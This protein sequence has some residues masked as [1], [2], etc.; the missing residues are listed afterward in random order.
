MKLGARS[1]LKAKLFP[2]FCLFF[3]HLQENGS[4]SYAN[5]DTSLL[6][7]PRCGDAKHKDK[8]SWVDESL[9][10]FK[11]KGKIGCIGI[12]IDVKV[13][14]YPPYQKGLILDSMDV[15]LSLIQ[16]PSNVLGI[17]FPGLCV[18]KETYRTKTTL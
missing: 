13:T 17:P 9:N 6:N 12:I 1:A 16:L 7:K 4:P 14:L 10:L 5:V 2:F 8:I 18:T 15:A 11:E 3:P